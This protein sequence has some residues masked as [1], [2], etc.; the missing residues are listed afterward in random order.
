[1]RVL[2]D[3]TVIVAERGMAFG[4]LWSEAHRSFTGFFRSCRNLPRWGA[5]EVLLCAPPPESGPR[6]CKRRV[7]RDGRLIRRDSLRTE[8]HIQVSLPRRFLTAQEC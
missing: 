8:P 3:E 6:Q 7:Q 5:S 2:Q 4:C 1:M